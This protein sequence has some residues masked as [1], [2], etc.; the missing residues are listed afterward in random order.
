[1]DPW[2]G[3]AQLTK[4]E[5]RDLQNKKLA[6]FVNSYVYPFSPHY[7]RLFDQHNI[8]PRAVKTV[9]DLKAVPFTSKHDFFAPDE[10]PEKFRDFILQPTK[11][12][13]RKYWP[14]AKSARLALS[15]MVRGREYVEDRLAREF[16][17]SFMTF[18]T[19]TTNKPIAHL[20]SEHDMA[21]LRTSGSRMLHLFDI[22]GSDRIVNMFPYA[23]HL[24]FWQVV[25]GG[26]DS[27]VLI[28]ST[29]GGKTLGTDGNISALLKM[30]PAV[31]VGVPCYVYHVLREAKE[32]GC[33]M[34]FLKKVV[35]GASRINTGFK[36]KVAELL[37]EMGAGDVSI[38]G[39][40]GFTEARAAWAECPTGINVSS[41]YHLYPDKEI[42]EVID[43]Q[44]GE[45][46]GE[47][48]D[49]ELVYTSLDA[50][51]S[52]VLRYRTGDFVKGGITYQP[53]AHCGRHV[54]RI[55]S[56][57][58]RLS[59]VKDL[60]LSKIKGSLVNLNNFMS[61]LSE[62]QSVDE[63]QIELRKKDNDPFEVDE[64]VVFVC[65]RSGADEGQLTE[66]IRK[67]MLLQTEVTPNEV[68][69]IELNDMIGR[70]ELEVSNKAK[71]IIDTRPTD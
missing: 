37:R 52:V 41:G 25:F 63:W 5:I 66:E 45:V 50:R 42:F 2:N 22:E 14:A 27:S 58:T 15:S 39:T 4:K 3:I 38:F 48:E 62:I 7:R 13:I 32:R 43:P 59:D 68:R 29:G 56:D 34:D 69:F 20:Y 44:T 16:R 11:E 33:T 31:L 9:D 47:G 24:A 61:I 10:N 60:Q 1:M 26:L 19:G 55:A 65:K 17:P 30:R 23:P 64:V 49:G 18:T 53:C 28:M 70:L 12:A 54:P 67:K 51:G 35:L 36:A 21:N 71:R 46:K 57:I 8:D 6:S 40:Y